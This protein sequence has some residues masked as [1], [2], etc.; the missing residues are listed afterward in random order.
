MRFANIDS[1]FSTNRVNY[2]SNAARIKDLH[3]NTLDGMQKSSIK[4]W[5]SRWSGKPA[6]TCIAVTPL[7][8]WIREAERIRA[9]LVS[10]RYFIKLISDSLH[11]QSYL[12]KPPLFRSFALFPFR[13][14]LF[15]IG[16]LLFEKENYRIELSLR[17]LYLIRILLQ[18]QQ[19]FVK[20]IH[21]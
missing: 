21:V 4:T 16:V 19:D 9:R 20:V 10:T 1:L 6:V 5:T 13:C 18:M 3:R 15:E 7:K 14:S 8:R 2:R 11:A 12:P 17:L